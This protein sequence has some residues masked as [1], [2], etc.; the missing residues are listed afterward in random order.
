MLADQRGPRVLQSRYGSLAGH[1]GKII[2]E[3]LKALSAL[4]VIQ[5]RLK[6]NAGPSKNRSSAE[7]RFVL[8]NQR[9]G[10]KHFPKTSAIR[11]P[12]AYSSFN[13]ENIVVGLTPL[14][15]RQDRRTPKSQ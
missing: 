2:E 11:V 8:D 3:L 4:Q 13:P 9:I 10:R 5:Q 12:S 6:R 15:R 1:S 14:K 7:D